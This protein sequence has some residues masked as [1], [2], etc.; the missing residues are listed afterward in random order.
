MWMKFWQFSCFC[1]NSDISQFSKAKRKGSENRREFI[2]ITRSKKTINQMQGG[3]SCLD[4]DSNQ[5]PKMIRRVNSTQPGYWWNRPKSI[6]Y[7]S[8]GGGSLIRFSGSP[9]REGGQEPGTRLIRV[10]PFGQWWWFRELNALSSTLHP[11]FPA[12]GLHALIR[13]V[14]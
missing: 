8:S 11:S 1:R 6:K 14:C 7:Q 13:A 4:T 9:P 10:R 5:P 2:Q 3:V 12:C